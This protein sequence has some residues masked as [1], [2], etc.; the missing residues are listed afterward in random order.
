MAATIFIVVSGGVAWADWWT[1]DNGRPA[2]DRN[3]PTE[4]PG[5]QP[6]E[7]V[8][9]TEQPTGNEPTA[10]PRV[11]G[12]ELTSTPIPTGGSSSTENPCD[13]GKPYTGDYCGWS[14]KVGG[15]SAGDSSS[16]PRIGGPEV[17]GLSYTSGS[18]LSYSD[19]I[20]LTGLLC[21]ALYVRSKFIK[22]PLP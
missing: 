5:S 15:E 11:G 14:P 3:F 1:R 2:F 9:P 18:D 13:P 19:I 16:N 17:Q 22:I 10:T 20:L 6:T 8:Q 4:S 12:V 7:G 21:L